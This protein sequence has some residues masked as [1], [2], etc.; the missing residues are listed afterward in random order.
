M[1]IKAVLFDMDGTLVISHPCHALAYKIL[2]KDLGIKISKKQISD[3]MKTPSEISFHQYKKDFKLKQQAEWLVNK[4]RI[5]VRQCALGKKYFAPNAVKTIQELKQKGCKL[6]IVTSSGRKTVDIF[7]PKQIQK[8]FDA[9]ISLEDV[10]H[11]KPSPEP[12]KK[13]L[14]KLK[15]KPSQAIMVGDSITDI[16][17]AKKAKIKAI[18]VTTGLSKK[19]ELLKQKPLAVIKNLKELKKFLD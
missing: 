11:I 4:K 19:P 12:M 8:N 9:I 5:I 18:G 3:Y 15:L 7:L 14:K 13:M 17:S 1:K 2:S 6:G 16:I 10:K